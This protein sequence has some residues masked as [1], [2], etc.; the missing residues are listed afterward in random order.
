MKTLAFAEASCPLHASWLEWMHKS[1]Q[2]LVL[3]ILSIL[4][5]SARALHKNRPGS[6]GVSGL[7]GIVGGGSGGIM[8]GGH[9]ASSAG[10]TSI[11][12]GGSHRFSR[13][14]S[15]S[16]QANTAFNS[17]TMAGGSGAVAVGV[18][19]GGGG[20]GNG[21]GGGGGG[22]G[23]LGVEG[24]GKWSSSGTSLGAV[25][26]RESLFVAKWIFEPEARTVE[27][28]ETSFLGPLVSICQTHCICCPLG[29][30]SLTARLRHVFIHN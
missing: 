17:G 14:F 10:S 12:G 29:W 18:S 11:G 7:S 5:V 4:P 26:A 1:L 15:S 9:F 13:R 16:T 25:R 23:A 30:A 19:G 28:R 2:H 6:T 8:I 20:G 24:S 3:Q 27:M 21:G 22:I